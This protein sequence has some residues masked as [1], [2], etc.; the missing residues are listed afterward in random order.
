MLEKLEWQSRMY[1]P[2]SL[3]TLGIQDT[4]KSVFLGLWY[5]TPLSTIFQLYRDGQFYI[6]FVSDL[7]QVCGFLRVLHIPPPIKLTVTI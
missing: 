5:L 4:G 1:N 2:E 6:K 7:Q 3:A